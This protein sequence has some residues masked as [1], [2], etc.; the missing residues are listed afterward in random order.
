MKLELCLRRIALSLGLIIS[1]GLITATA[2]APEPSQPVK[3][4]D[5]DIIKV[6]TT[7]VTVPVSVTDRNG[8]FIADL[9]QDQFRL[10]EDGVEQRI[11]FFENASQP[12]TIALMLDVSD[13][14]KEKLTQIKSAATAF[15]GELKENDRVMVM[16]FDKNITV[17]CN[18]T[19]D[20][21]LV[22]SAI[23]RLRAGGGTSL[24]DALDLMAARQMKK[25]H[26]RKAIVLF[27]DGV[28]TTSNSATYESTLRAAEELDALIYS[29]QYDTLNDVEKNQNGTVPP[30]EIGNQVV[31]SRGE[32]LSVAYQ[33]A[34]LYL[35]ALSD[36]TA[37]R[38]YSAAGLNYLK[39]IFSR[40]AAELR[41][42]YSLGYY[43]SNKSEGKKKRQVRVRIDRSNVA[44]RYRR[45]YIYSPR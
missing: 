40:I 28:D 5:V 38:F 21:K 43:P 27:T 8:R 9:K 36:K 20:R 10:F 15:V 6:S 30:G 26:G 44:L 2:Q 18:P 37:G 25:I 17:L 3:D 42:Q 35:Q 39:G 33:R 7:L 29:I 24:Y 19:S 4:Q 1:L 23:D 14:A 31:T 34:G 11:A 32:P 16:S 22:T 12:F 45:T 41:E 13:S